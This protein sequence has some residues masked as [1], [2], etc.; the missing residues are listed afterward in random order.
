MEMGTAQKRIIFLLLTGVLLRL[1]FLQLDGYSTDEIFSLSTARGIPENL[2]SENH[3]LSVRELAQKNTLKDFYYA[4]QFND[5]GNSIL[6]HGLLFVIKQI[7]NNTLWIRS[8]GIIWFLINGLLLYKIA[9]HF[10]NDAFAAL[11][12]LVLAVHPFFIEFDLTIRAYS[13]SLMFILLQTHYF[14]RILQGDKSRKT[15]LLFTAACL[16]AFFSHFLTIYIVFF[17]VAFFILTQRKRFLELL[18]PGF[19]FAGVLIAFYLINREG[20]SWMSHRNQILV[21]LATADP[22][23]KAS[24]SNLLI[25]NTAA[26]FRMAGIHAEM[27]NL[28]FRNLLFFILPVLA[29][30]SAGWWICRKKQLSQP[31]LAYLI[32]LIVFPFVI[33]TLTAFSA[34][35]TFTF[36]PRYFIWYMPFFSILIIYLLSVQSFRFVLIAGLL[37]LTPLFFSD[38]EFYRKANRFS[39]KIRTEHDQIAVQLQTTTRIDFRHTFY[40]LYVLEDFKLKPDLQINY[41]GN[42]SDNRGFEARQFQLASTGGPHTLYGFEG[43]RIVLSPKPE[44]FY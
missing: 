28:R 20:W 19:L 2:F 22:S 8:L 34:G 30:L 25:E 21:D 33:S 24:F 31:L 4:N 15:A 29:I 40:L 10:L 17:N 43:F 7:D 18:L 14:F 13:F 5:S 9:R 44:P 41:V 11:V 23:K 3:P 35:H 37:A 36:Q 1:L 39:E 16:L 42:D 32:A 6:Y 26:F 12:L 27:A 38:Y